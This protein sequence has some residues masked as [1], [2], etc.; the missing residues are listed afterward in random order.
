HNV[1]QPD[2]K[3]DADDACRTLDRVGRTHERFD[4]RR[5]R[6]VGFHLQEPTREYRGVRSDLLPEQI[7]HAGI[8]RAHRTRSRMAWNNRV[9]SISPTERPGAE[10]TPRV[11]LA[12]ARASVGAAG[13]RLSP[14]MWC[15]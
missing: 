14:A 1:R 15:T 7:E 8:D 3:I 5:V 4:L 2:A 12:A 11:S 10:N 6:R 9:S 13:V